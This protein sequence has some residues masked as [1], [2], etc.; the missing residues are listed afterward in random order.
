MPTT[1]WSTYCPKGDSCPRYIRTDYG[2]LNA[3]LGNSEVPNLFPNA[4]QC[5]FPA[6]VKNRTSG[7]TVRFIGSLH[8][9]ASIPY[10][11]ILRFPLA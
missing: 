8:V 2:C 3:G 5:F 7:G 1:Q 11:N 4:P 9:P 6:G 10:A